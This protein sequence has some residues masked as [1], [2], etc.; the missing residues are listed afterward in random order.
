M[1]MAHSDGV[2][3][4][5]EFDEVVEQ[6]ETHL[7]RARE[8]YDLV[9]QLGKPLSGVYGAALAELDQSIEAFDS[10]Y[11]VT[12]VELEQARTI[13]T[14]AR[15]LATLT[16][17]YRNYYEA[18]VDRQVAIFS[19][20]FDTLDS[21]EDVDN[22]ADQSTLRQQIQAIR[23]LISARKYGQLQSSERINLKEIKAGIETFHDSVRETLTS[24]E[25]ISVTLKLARSFKDHY[26]DD[27]SMLVQSGVK[28]EAISV[29]EDVQDTPE[30]DPIATRL[31]GNNTTDGDIDDVRTVVQT[32][33]DIALLTGRRQ[34]RY[35]LGEALISAIEK[36]NFVDA[37]NA[38]EELRPELSSFEIEFIEEQVEG[39]VEGEATT[40][41]TERLLQ[42][43]A[44]HD[45]SVQ[46][47]LR[48]VGRSPDEVF[49]QLQTMLEEGTFEDLEVRFE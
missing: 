41:K 32:Y 6:A 14:R 23:K 38:V 5:D 47:T 33:A 46:R 3:I 25:Y 24:T 31:E 18:V 37:E 29:V 13:A 17:A 36:S 7:E 27:L 21:V 15:F 11:N 1:G 19:E 22:A 12:D 26:T 10:I 8:N 39:L 4:W 48:T 30:L 43:L 44:E 16:A 20:W 28:K 40:S 34:A 45:G 9:E 49:D 2:D 42:L 35:E